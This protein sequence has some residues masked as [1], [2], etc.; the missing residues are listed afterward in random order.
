MKKAKKERLQKAG[1]K[2]GSVQDFLGLSDEEAAMVAMKL[3]L[4]RGLKERRV[5]QGLTQDELAKRLGSSQSRVAKME[6]ADATVSIDLVIR[7]LLVLG[8]T[9]EQVGRII[10]HRGGPPVA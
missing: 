9:R 8:V 10:G 7:A 1:W 6:S 5:A 3:A 2:V 4:A